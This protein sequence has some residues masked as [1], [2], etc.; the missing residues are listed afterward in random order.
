[1]ELALGA[2]GAVQLVTAGAVQIA[3]LLAA[4]TGDGATGATGATGR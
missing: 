4:I 1:V 2:A 3:V